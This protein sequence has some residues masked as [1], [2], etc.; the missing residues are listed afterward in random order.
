MPRSLLRWSLPLVPVVSL[1]PPVFLAPLLAAAL[2]AGCAAPSAP[3]APARSSHT[4]SL[5]L[6]SGACGPAADRVVRAV[7][8]VHALRVY[9]TQRASDGETRLAYA[10]DASL[11]PDGA[12][13]L[14]GLPEGS[15]YKLE[16][17]GQGASGTWYGMRPSVD[18]A[19]DSSA[20]LD[21]LLTRLGTFSQVTVDTSFTN[22]L[23]PATVELGDGRVMVSG[24]FQDVSEQEV[25]NP[26]RQWFI[27][28]PRT[29][30]LDAKGTVP[31]GQQRG[32]HTMVYLPTTNEVLF[33]GGARRLKVD[34]TRPFPVTYS[35]SQGNG[36]S[37]G[38]VFSVTDQRFAPLSDDHVMKTGIKALGRAFPRA[39]VL[40]NGTVVVTG[41]GEWP[42]DNDTDF[43]RVSVFDPADGGRFLSTPGLTTLAA[44]AGHSMTFL[45]QGADGAELLLWGG[46]PDGEEVA[47]VLTVSRAEDGTVSGTAAPVVI[48]GETPP[49]TFFQVL[50]PLGGNRFLAT[51][52]ARPDASDGGRLGAPQDDEAWLVTY[53]EPGGQPTV[54]LDAVPGLGAG[55][56]FHG[57]MPTADH[58]SVFVLGGFAG[59]KALD[60]DK[61]MRFDTGEMRWDVAPETGAFLGRGA[62]AVVPM[63]NGKALLVGGES[64]L[65]NKGD[66]SCGY[67]EVFTPSSITAP[68]GT[69]PGS[70]GGCA[71]AG[72]GGPASPWL[73]GL[74]L[75]LLAAWTRARRRRV[76]PHG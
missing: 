75:A 22:V 30:T 52:G 58:G 39:A 28:D 56:V 40:P 62:H 71:G 37:Q 14:G 29:G 49:H 17:F 25:G 65:A 41:G 19:A 23:F 31:D 76:A 64:A 8:D 27:L 53:G 42:T 50:T 18:I 43:R 60:H 55:R 21:L 1:V 6:G 16:V 68:T 10:G 36:V 61:V 69:A 5:P 67:V 48:E 35:K 59:D 70:G 26:S 66:V 74:A 44:R 15:G 46:V 33:V 7:D 45:G 24:G 20:P 72:G 57:A 47:E 73:P 51:G 34:T 12:L 38:L 2:A 63:V 32:A 3:E 54:T 13:D 9:L 4:V 11:R